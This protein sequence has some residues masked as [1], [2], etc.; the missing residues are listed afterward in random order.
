MRGLSSRAALLVAVLAVFLPVPQSS[1]ELLIEI[2]R[3]GG[4]P[5]PLAV[6]PFTWELPGH[7]QGIIADIIGSDLW[8]TGRFSTLPRSQMLSTPGAGQ[9]VFFREWQQLQVDY[10]VV[11]TVSPAEQPTGLQLRMELHDVHGR[12]LL[13][14]WVEHGDSGQLRDLAHQLSNRLY[15]HLVKKRGVFSSRMAYISRV[16]RGGIA[17]YRLV[18]ADSDGA[19][20]RV[21]Y[22]RNTPLL[23]PAWAPD[24]QSLAYVS[25]ERGRAAIYHQQLASG[26]P[27][28]LLAEGEYSSAPAFSP[29]GNRLAVTIARGG[30]IDIYLLALRKG[31]EN[32]AA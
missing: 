23:S 22:E 17:R 4:K 6:V 5:T 10:L 24:G 7:A 8:R 28:L 11:G 15:Q 29:D 19:R 16:E 18:V 14:S 26:A 21:L 3:G 12:Q 25:F 30:N 32:C 13:E 20:G 31:G 9:Q 1:A 27:Q 2:T